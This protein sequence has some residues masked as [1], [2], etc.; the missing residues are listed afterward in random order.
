MKPGHLRVLIL[1]G[2][3]TFGRLR[4]IPRRW[5]VLGVPLPLVLAPG[6]EAFET[7]ADGRFHFHVEIGHRL[8]GL[9]V[10]CRGWLEPV[11]DDG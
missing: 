9:A 6:G 1:G 2:Y 11:A 7:A 5:S 8:F 10:R 4:L 3:G